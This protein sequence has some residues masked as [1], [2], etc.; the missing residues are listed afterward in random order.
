MAEPS[1]FL[2]KWQG[3]IVFEIALAPR[4]DEVGLG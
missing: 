4:E 3:E 2:G 1:G